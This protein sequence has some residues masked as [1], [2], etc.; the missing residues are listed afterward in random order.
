MLAIENTT[1]L[2]EYINTDYHMNSL[3]FIYIC[4]LAMF[5]LLILNTVWTIK[6]CKAEK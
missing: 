4:L 3:A 1:R 5:V 6:S 2:A